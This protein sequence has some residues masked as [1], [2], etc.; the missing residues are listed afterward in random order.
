MNQNA[1]KWALKMFG[2]APSQLEMVMPAYKSIL[3]KGLLRF[4]QYFGSA[5]CIQMQRKV[6]IYPEDMNR[7]FQTVKSVCSPHRRCVLLGEDS[8]THLQEVVSHFVGTY[9]YL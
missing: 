2:K 4:S 5:I 3:V 8:S 1:L 6:N 7:Y 9:L